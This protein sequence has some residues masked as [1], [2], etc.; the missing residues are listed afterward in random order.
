[1]TNFAFVRAEWP[2]LFAEAACAEYNGVGDPRTSC[3]YARRCLELTVGWL[4]DADATL[5]APYRDD[6]SARLGEPSLR[7][8]VGADVHAKMDLI[9]R[10]GNRAVHRSTPITP[11]DSL[12]VVGQLFQVLYWLAR[13]YSRDPANLP[14]TDVAF[15]I[16]AIP[17]PVPASVR[18]Q[19]QAELQAQAARLAEQDAAIARAREQNAGL[20]AELAELRALIAAAK[21]ANEARPDTHDYDEATTRSLIIDALL[22]EAGWPLEHP[23]DREFEVIGM[24]APNGG[25]GRGF[26][27]YVLWGDDG[28]PLGLVEAKRTRRDARVGQQ[29]AKLYADCLEARFEQRPVIFYSNGY[30]TW[31]WDDT[32]YPPRSVQG[33]YTR[34][35]LALLVQRRTTRLPLA[36]TAISSRIVER[37]YQHRAIRRVGEAFEVS[38]QRQA[39]VVMATGAGKTRA[40]IALVDL[41]VRSNWCK[42]VLFLADRVALV[43]QAVGAFKTHLPTATTVNLVT[44]KAIDGRVYVATY[45]TMMGLINAGAGDQRRFGPGYF[46]V[47]VIDEA[48]RSVYQKYGAIFDWFD[49]LLVG[50][51]ATPKDEIDRN[52]YRLFHLE[53]GVPTDA[54]PLGEAVSEGYLVPARGINVPLKFPREGIR[55]DDLSEEDKEEWDKR[56]WDEDGDVPDSV[57]SDAVNKWLF[58]ADTVDKVLHTLMTVGHRVAGGDR[59]GKTIIFARNNHHAEFIRDRFD[60]NYPEY[61]G[62]FAR[63]ITHRVEY[64][65]SLID[66]FSVKEKAPHI[67]IS[68]DMLDTGVDVPEVVNLVF[69]KPVRSKTKFWQMLGRGTRLCPDLFGP[70]DDKVDFRVLDVCGN[71]EFFNTDPATVDGQLAESLAQRLFKARL[72]ML[73]GLDARLST[74]QRAAEPST[75]TV[76]TEGVYVVSPGSDGTRTERGLRRDI[77]STLQEIVAAMNVDNF[78][79]RPQRQWVEIYAEL[80]RWDDL[81]EPEAAEVGER[82]SG[83]PS[84]VTDADELAKRFDLL[85]LRLQLGT[86]H[87]EPGF[88]RLRDQ[89]REIA[90]AL[91]EVAN[92]PAVREQQDLLDEVSGEQWWVDVTLPM[93]ELLRRRVRLLV[94]LIDK[95]RRLVVYTDFVDQIGD[96]TD[97]TISGTPVST[98]FERFQAKARVYLRTHQDHLALQKLKRNKPLTVADVQDLER[99]LA[100]SGAGAPEDIERARAQADGLGLFMRSL[101]GLDREAATDVLSGF[102]AGRTLGASQLDFLSQIVNYLTEH[103]V[104][105]A[106]LL[107]ES[108]FT[109]L[110]PLGPESLF[111]SDEVGLLIAALEQVR[112]TAVG[113]AAA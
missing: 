40:V 45:P 38:R 43:T 104:M 75:V 16:E 15:D 71:L 69:F 22:K 50:L 32:R 72:E 80:D 5:S 55:Y 68:V 106:G 66:D 34:D 61:A 94:R 2:E 7:A 85:I 42:R 8:L 10:S 24:P 4:Y 9:R 35:E 90:S 91:L 14:A 47:V 19:R 92:I 86:L 21:V 29:Q 64:A 110:A 11:G 59:L 3:F 39:L 82:L 53:D 79:V 33:F 78:V 60:A 58:N 101:I 97:V 63:V 112:L 84:R 12:P 46:D 49:S 23:E 107:Y 57:A 76:E 111:T 103:G 81:S 54:Y 6:L 1:V 25:D 65:Q 17:R 62:A 73:T 98:D 20:E 105:E 109:D 108:P 88:D 56:D 99:M 70:G 26:V 31:M 13:H 95:A 83:L 102:V 93:L 41:L 87:P 51:T 37:H 52:T 48:H 89:V 30:E 113:V 36:E 96:V 77:A 67:A 100:E 27:D 18:V 44:E 28:K 74:A